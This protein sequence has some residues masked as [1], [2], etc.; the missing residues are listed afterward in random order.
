[1]TL[2]VLLGYLSVAVMVLF[3]AVVGFVLMKQW[4]QAILVAA[5]GSLSLLVTFFRMRGAAEKITIGTVAAEP[6]ETDFG[7]LLRL[8]ANG[9]TYP[10]FVEQLPDGVQSGSLVEISAR[11]SES[12]SPSVAGVIGNGKWSALH[13]L[14]G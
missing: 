8:K 12:D 3:I 9:S 4:G 13:T 14:Q 11:W 6:K 7:F 10:V 1:M 5:L 2:M